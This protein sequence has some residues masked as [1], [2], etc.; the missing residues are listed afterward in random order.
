MVPASPD[1]VGFSEVAVQIA[2]L[3]KMNPWT[4]EG[5]PVDGV[6]VLLPI[7]FNLAEA[8]ASTSTAPSAPPAA[9]KP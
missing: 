1:G 6:T 3:M 7:R 2:Q 9:A 8:S 5:G 4:Q